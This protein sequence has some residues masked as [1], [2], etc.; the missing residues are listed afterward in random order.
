MIQ[1]FSFSSKLCKIGETVKKGVFF[2]NISHAVTNSAYHDQYK[3]IVYSIESLLLAFQNRCNTLII[4]NYE[5]MGW[6][7]EMFTN[8][9]DLL[10]SV[11]S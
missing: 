6:A 8:L 3:I 2:Y 11:F 1:K 9:E 7:Q 10:Y 5:K 4:Y